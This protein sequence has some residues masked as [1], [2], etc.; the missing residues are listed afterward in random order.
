MTTDKLDLVELRE[1]TEKA[2]ERHGHP[3]YGVFL[4]S[5]R[6]LAD[7]TTVLTLI[8]RV[9]AAEDQLQAEQKA[10]AT[11]PSC[12]LLRPEHQKW[13]GN[14]VCEIWRLG[15]RLATAAKLIEELVGALVS[16]GRYAETPFQ[17]LSVLATAKDA[18]ALHDLW[19]KGDTDASK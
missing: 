16:V 14:P 9:E 6:K 10:S 19:K 18:L 12:G 15:D 11:C 1:A 2:K 17:Q 3:Y 8:A 7:P 5:F 4:A 13:C